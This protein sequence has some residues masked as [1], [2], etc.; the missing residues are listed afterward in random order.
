MVVGLGGR[1][2]KTYL[3]KAKAPHLSSAAQ[4][5]VGLR[6]ESVPPRRGAAP[7]TV[8]AGRCE[9]AYLVYCRSRG[10]CKTTMIRS[11]FGQG[12]G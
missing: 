4:S 1:V 12:I 9:A 2:L 6:R 11:V 10:R 8:V 7:E 3:G 5:R